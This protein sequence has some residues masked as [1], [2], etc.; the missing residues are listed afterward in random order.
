MHRLK[1]LYSYVYTQSTVCLQLQRALN[2][3]RLI[4]ITL[5]T[6]YHQIWKLFNVSYAYIMFTFTGMILRIS[7]HLRKTSYIYIS[8]CTHWLITDWQSRKVIPFSKDSE[9]PNILPENVYTAV[10]V[11]LETLI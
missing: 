1:C 9:L 3:P 11:L 10:I 8:Q 2:M 7:Y 5:Y 4:V 6:C